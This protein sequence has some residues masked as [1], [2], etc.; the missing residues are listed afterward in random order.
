MKDS[1][2]FSTEQVFSIRW[3]I[4]W[5]TKKSWEQRWW[6]G[7]HH[8][9]QKKHSLFIAH[10][11][12]CA[13]FGGL[14]GLLALFCCLLSGL[15]TQGEGACNCHPFFFLHLTFRE[16]R[17]LPMW[18]SVLNHL[19]ASEL[20]KRKHNDQEETISWKIPSPFSSYSLPIPS[21]VLFLSLKYRSVL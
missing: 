11:Q 15:E 4:W 7:G 19:T 2:V 9:T 8:L 12:D 21:S 1:G 14:A 6:P 10:V 20:W 16:L 3:W 13:C 5:V 17:E 18:K